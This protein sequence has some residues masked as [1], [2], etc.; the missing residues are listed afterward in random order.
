MY[1]KLLEQLYYI[2]R[3]ITGKNNRKSL[4]IIKNFIPIKIKSIKS[5]TKIF[6]WKVPKEWM[7]AKHG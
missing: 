6:D 1:E 5:G 3:S 7:L 4:R 2:P